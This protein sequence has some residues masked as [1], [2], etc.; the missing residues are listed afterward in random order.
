M[1]EKEKRRIWVENPQMRVWIQWGLSELK[2]CKGDS[3]K[4]RYCKGAIHSGQE[5][6]NLI[7]K[8]MKFSQG[9]FNKVKIVGHDSFSK[10]KLWKSTP[11]DANVHYLNTFLYLYYDLC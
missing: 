7:T 8:R 9:I 2:T 11:N 3:N 10:D 6:E 4:R 1:K 5:N